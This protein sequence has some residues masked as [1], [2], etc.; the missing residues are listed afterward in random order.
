MAF[1]ETKRQILHAG[2]LVF[3]LLL[4]FLP[5]WAAL[6]CALTAFVHNVLV[7][8]RTGR[9]TFYR[10]EDDRRGFP[11]GIVLYPVTVFLLILLFGA[12]MHIAG[13]AWAILAFGDGFATIVGRRLGR[14]PLP[15][16]PEKSFEGSAAYVL[17]GGTAAV[18][19]A[20]WIGSPE[21]DFLLATRHPMQGASVGWL[22]AVC[23]AGALLAAL[24]ETLPLGIDDN[25]SAPLLAGFVMFV[26][27]GLEPAQ[28]G[29][30][31][32]WGEHNLLLGLAVS[33]LVA[34]ASYR[35]G[36]VSKN[37]LAGGLA[38]GTLV[39]A[40]SG[41][42]GFGIL[43]CFFLIGSLVSRTGY[44][45][46]AAIGAAQ[47]EG[48]RRGSKHAA[49]NC[50]TGLLLGL[51]SLLDPAYAGLY[52]LGMVASFA[53]ALGDTTSSELGSIYGKRPFL[54][55]T[56]QRVPPGTE[57]AV[58]VEGTL[59][60]IAF[61]LLLSGCGWAL[62]LIPLP[63]VPLSTAGAFVGMSFESY[64]GAATRSLDNEL[65]NF[66]NTLVGAVAAMLLGGWLL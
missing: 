47:E 52:L 22:V 55:T 19:V 26:L 12:R 62:G 9:A 18:L 44:Q 3:A 1:D 37:G 21:L 51:A 28:A 8:P 2:M 16:C 39:I 40:G 38:V 11:L 48:G 32:A 23:F 13:A 61:A 33:G 10:P 20:L 31:V 53:T 43:L 27:W 66:L 65:L 45:K 59:I 35:A 56:F 50:T 58:S 15:W 36:F 29:Q 4:R 41:L 49:A 30:L 6:L 17:F 57:G 46:K 25:L 5:W 54:L 60:G 14:H 24:V 7:L 42:R 63:A 64:L 34:V